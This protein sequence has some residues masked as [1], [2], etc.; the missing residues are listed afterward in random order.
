MPTS[1]AEPFSPAP[2]KNIGSGS[3]QKIYAPTVSDSEKQ[4]LIQNIRKI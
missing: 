3:T 4:I 1:V 2:G